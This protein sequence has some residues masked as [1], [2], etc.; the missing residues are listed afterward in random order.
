MLRTLSQHQK[1]PGLLIRT[2]KLLPG[3]QHPS[4]LLRQQILKIMSRR[5]CSL[6][7]PNEP[8]KIVLLLIVFLACRAA[9]QNILTRTSEEGA[10]FRQQCNK[11]DW[12]TGLPWNVCPYSS[13]FLLWDL[14][15]SLPVTRDKICGICCLLCGIRISWLKGVI[16]Y[17]TQDQPNYP[18][19]IPSVNPD[20]MENTPAD[21]IFLKVPQE[22]DSTGT[23]SGAWGGRGKQ[24]M[25]PF[26]S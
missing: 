4:S 13:C 3:Y 1:L 2:E 9:E 17:Q 12:R 11:Q 15:C 23:S 16:N 22:H 5:S 6:I 26:S 24:K 7:K 20:P 18:S 19:A 21:S 14:W 8:L 25:P 10:G